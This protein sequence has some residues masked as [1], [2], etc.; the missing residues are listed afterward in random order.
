MNKEKTFDIGKELSYDKEELEKSK[1]FLDEQEKKFAGLTKEERI[2]RYKYLRGLAKGEILGAPTGYPSIDLPHLKFIPEE[3]DVDTI[4]QKTMWEVLRDNAK[5]YPDIDAL[6]YEGNHI[7]YKELVE[8]CEKC[9]KSFKEMGITDKDHVMICMANIPEF[10]YSFYGLIHIGAVPN[11]IEPRTNAKRILNYISTANSKYMV[12]IDKCYE[13]IEKIA[14]ESSLEKIISVSPAESLKGI[15]KALYSLANKKVSTHGKYIDYKDFIN[16]GKGK[17]IVDTFDYIPDRTT[18]VVYTSGTSGVPKG[19]E[20]RN[21]TYNGQNLQIKYSGFFPKKGEIFMGNV[22]FFSAY[23]SSSGMHN[24]LSHG[25]TIYL[26]P[27]PELEKFPKYIFKTKSTFVM[28]SPR[29]F[30]I[31]DKYLTKHPEKNI[32]FLKVMCSGGDKILEAHEEHMNETFVR[33]GSAPIKKGMGASEHGGG[34]TTTSTDLDNKI[35]SVG[36]PLAQNI[37]KIVDPST[38]IELK[39]NQEGEIYVASITHANGYLNNEVQTKKAFFKDSLGRVWYRTADLGY[40]DEDGVLFVTGR[41]SRAIMRPDGHTVSLLPIENVV[42]HIPGVKNCAVI[43][44]KPSEDTAGELPMLFVSLKEGAD[45]QKVQIDIE[46]ECKE[47][48]PIRENPQWVRYIEEL[49]YTLM[50][51]VDYKKLEELAT[52]KDDL[53]EYIV[54]YR[55]VVNKELVLKL[56]KK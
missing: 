20:L 31:F 33:A 8:N 25:V 17:D 48:I 18:V 53:V 56:Q 42:S 1:I 2:L 51:K 35:G 39:Y 15:K 13:N 45:L 34:Y 26:I 23:G 11:L 36:I 5:E 41:S 9:A 32:S 21:E 47:N 40:I 43:G 7:S 28:G 37:I 55:N 6:I 50:E 3:A 46:K 10:V 12:M 22:P 30:E 29:H 54:D 19:I 16:L 38:G 24:A 27:A 52:E 49:P 4:A 44:R 14:N